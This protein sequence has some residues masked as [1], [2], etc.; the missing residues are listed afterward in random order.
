MVVLSFALANSL[1]AHF[2][3]ASSNTRQNTPD[4]AK[5]FP[6]AF[7]RHGPLTRQVALTF[8]DGPDLVYTPKILQILRTE[9]IHA[10]FFVLGTNAAHYPMMIHQIMA[11][12]NALGNHSFDHKNLI[13]SSST[14][15]LWE[16]LATDRILVRI[17][18]HS[19]KWFR[20]P[21]GNVNI[22]I[23]KQ[24]GQLGYHT[25]NWSV[26]SNDWRGLSA[27]AVTRNIIRDVRPG[28]IILQHC[29]GNPREDLTG[30][31][32]A[33]PEIIH[34]LRSKG[35]KFVTVPEMLTPDSTL[36]H[37]QNTANNCHQ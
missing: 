29:A 16:V 14:Q 3:K 12:G 32:K 27:Q 17:T 19:P 9:H 30:T 25:V 2:V 20:P 33:L 21:Y 23:L 7:F 28:A 10:T 31:V 13:K 37:A 4:Y 26:D 8:D 6:H 1:T 24:L 36:V 22:G 34:I 15:L 5:L 35:Y 18:G 11:D